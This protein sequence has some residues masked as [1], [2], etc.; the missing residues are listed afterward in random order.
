M[1]MP[2]PIVPKPTRHPFTL[3]DI[4]ILIAAISVGLVGLRSFLA[5][6]PIPFLSP[7]ADFE[8]QTVGMTV[9]VAAALTLALIVVPVRTFRSRL[10]RTARYPGMTAC[11][12]AA[13]ALLMIAMHSAIR[14]Q[15]FPILDG[16]LWLYYARFTLDSSSGAGSEWWPPWSSQYSPAAA[17]FGPTRPTG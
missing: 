14:S 12:G 5:G 2:N 8:R 10:R 11:C 9:P 4:M 13:T 1:P 3:A 6:F 16:T 7:Y 15:V 17:G